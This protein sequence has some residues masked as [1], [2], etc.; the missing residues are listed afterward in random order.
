M[1]N[2]F[3]IKLHNTALFGQYWKPQIAKAVIVLVHGMGEHS[4]R[5]KESVIPFLLKGNYA[6]V[7]YDLF[8]HGKTKGKRGNCSGYNALL[9]SLELAIDKAQTLFNNLPV[10][11]YGHSLGGNIVINYALKRQPKIKAI[12]ATSPFLRLAFKL[13]KWKVALGKLLFHVFPSIT[14][15]SEIDVEAISTIPSQVQQYI[16]DPLVHDK[17]S[18]NYLF[19]VIE[20]GEYAITNAYKLNVPIFITHG[21]ADRIIDFKGSV[22]FCKH[23]KVSDLKLYQDCFHELHHDICA[24]EMIKAIVNWLDKQ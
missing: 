21:T 2:T 20:A 22:A 6:V 4:G 3:T 14:L 10:F 1:E 13:P 23:S 8:G 11:I 18:P 19:P 9:D 7:A 16:Q 5:Y 17:I 24:Q 12:I 15:P